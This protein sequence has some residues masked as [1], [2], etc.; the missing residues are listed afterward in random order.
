MFQCKQQPFPCTRTGPSFGRRSCGAR[1]HC[2]I[3]IGHNPE[4]SNYYFRQ[5][6]TLCKTLNI[7]PRKFGR[8]TYA[9]KYPTNLFSTTTPTLASY[10]YVPCAH[11]SHCLPTILSWHSH[12]PPWILQMPLLL[13]VGLH[14]QSENG[15]SYVYKTLHMR[16]WIEFPPKVWKHI[17]AWTLTSTT[18]LLVLI[19]N[20]EKIFQCQ[21]IKK[22]TNQLPVWR[23]WPQSDT[24][25]DDKL[26]AVVP[27][28][29]GSG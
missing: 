19:T 29:S 20:L 7:S 17:F 9:Q 24:R 10:P 23:W 16:F 28:E 3:R 1:R 15:S 25:T 4:N 18:L 13:P 22:I 26:R 14:S 27:A 6:S 5:V 8:S 2:H 12:W 11:L 21:I